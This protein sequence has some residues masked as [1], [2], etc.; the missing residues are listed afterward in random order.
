MSYGKAEQNC[1][2]SNEQANSKLAKAMT[3]TSE[4]F[5]STRPR[6]D[7]GI[8]FGLSNLCKE[9]IKSLEYI[10]DNTRQAQLRQTLSSVIQ[11][12][13]GII[14]Q[15]VDEQLYKLPRCDCN[16]L[17]TATARYRELRH[18]R[19]EDTASLLSCFQQADQ[20]ALQE[21]RRAFKSIEDLGLA[22]HLSSLLA[23]FQISSDQIA[24]RR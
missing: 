10:R 23:T 15:L 24:N 18:G 7:L 2:E 11:T 6:P 3:Q 5:Q 17:Q 14:D 1:L 16:T 19:D 12:R 22:C 8:V 9:S 4:S 21:L 13:Q 20:L